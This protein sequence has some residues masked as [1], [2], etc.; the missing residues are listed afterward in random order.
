MDKLFFKAWSSENV[1]LDSSRTCVYWSERIDLPSD[2][3]LEY[4]NKV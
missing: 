2:T 3:F 4:G 1:M